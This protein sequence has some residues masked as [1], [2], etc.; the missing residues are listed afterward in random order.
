MN[1]RVVEGPPPESRKQFRLAPGASGGKATVIEMQPRAPVR[2]CGDCT[3]CCK[4]L[5][6][7]ALAKPSGRWCAHCEIGKGC[8]IYAERPQACRDFNCGWLMMP[9]LDER[10]KPSECKLVI[11]ASAADRRLTIGVDPSR[12]EAWRKEPYYSR[13]KLWAQQGLK[14][15]G[16]VLVAI[17]RRVIWIAPDRD[18]DLGEVGEGECV[19]TVRRMTPAGPR[20]ETLKLSEDDPRVRAAESRRLFPLA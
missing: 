2:Q 18:V 10:W 4:V 15:D 19:V 13:I 3:L 20:Q 6:V 9:E 12:P 7:T 16:S 14:N 11:A 1:T 17:G 8:A 5:E